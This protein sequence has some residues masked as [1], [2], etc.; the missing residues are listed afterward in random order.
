LPDD[1]VAALARVEVEGLERRSIVLD[2]GVVSGDV[3]PGTHYV[4]ALGQLV[5]IE[6]AK[7]GQRP[8]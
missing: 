8:L 1:L 3:T 4:R 7:T 6:I 2:E 5:G